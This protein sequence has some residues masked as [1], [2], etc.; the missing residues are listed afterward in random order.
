MT[1]THGN[2]DGAMRHHAIFR[3]VAALLCAAVM[4]ACDDGLTDFNVN[5]NEPVN[6]P[7]QYLLAN[8]TEA[9]A[10]RINGAYLNMDIVGLWVQ[11]YAEHLYSTEDRYELTD[12]AV[13]G[14][15]NNF[16]S[17]PLQDLQEVIEQGQSDGRP[18]VVAVGTIVKSWVF[19]VVTDL[20]GDVG[21][22]EALRGR[23]SDAL[24]VGYDTQQSIYND[25]LVQLTGATAAIDPAGV[26][27]TTGDLLYNGDMARWRKFANSLR[28]RVAMRLSEADLNKAR[29]E[30]A[31]AVAAGVFTA[32]S[33]NARVQYFDDGVNVHPIYGY[34]RSRDDHAISATL[35]DTLKA[36]GDPRLPLYAK[37]NSFGE[38]KGV[39]NGNTD[40]PPLNQVSRIGTYFSRADAQAVIMSYAEVLFLQAEA[41]ERGWIGGSAGD[42]YRQGITAAM[43]LMGISQTAITAYL[44]QD[45]VEYKGGQAG[46]RQIWLQ[47]WIAL[48]GNGPE[49]YAEWRRTGT[50]ELLPGPDALNDGRIPVRLPYPAVETALNKTAVDAAVAR[51]GGAGFNDRV[52]WHR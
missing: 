7:A 32:N 46:L 52:W 38:Y 18:N 23:A 6:V 30:F 16:Y 1:H 11:H 26:K 17:G 14:H 51:Q 29:T 27:L 41:A 10:N 35:V 50:P 49:A 37:P 25:L 36:L 2:G 44:N 19:Q 3:P 21:Y 15:W 13:A 24:E 33:D 28:L 40:S 9:A 34:E 12:A 4:G 45:A 43:S 22:S 31:A 20:W 42:F 48:F 8:A 5:P 47:K 39:Q